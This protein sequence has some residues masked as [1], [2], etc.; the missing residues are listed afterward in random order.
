MSTVEQRTKMERQVG[1][2]PVLPQ[3]LVRLLGL[4]SES[5]DFFEQLVDVVQSEPNYT[6]RILAVANSVLSG[7]TVP[8]STLRNAIARI[9]TEGA[10]NMITALSVT[11]VFVPRTPWE[12][13]LWRH[14]LQVAIAAREFARCA[15]DPQCLPDEAYVCGLLH[16]I[17]HFVL[18]QQRPD[19]LREVDEGDWEDPAGLLARESA[20][21]GVTHAELGA[22]ACRRWKLPEIVCDCVLHHHDVPAAEPQGASAKLAAIVRVADFAMFASVRPGARPISEASDQT[23]EQLVLREL[24]PFIELELPEL[25]TL[26]RNV[27][28]EAAT[29]ESLLGLA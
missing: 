9:G 14:A 3:A 22:I 8:I 15:R 21:C 26:L 7:T 29:V 16:D 17:G 28:T 24:P 12:K 6:V 10:A 18:F 20:V 19:M 2:L 23:L 11:R 13:G 25:R 4:D 5:P 27:V 1:R